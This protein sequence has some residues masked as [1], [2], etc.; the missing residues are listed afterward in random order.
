MYLSLPDPDPEKSIVDRDRA[1]VT[2][3]EIP[4]QQTIDR[5]WE[6]AADDPQHNQRPAWRSHAFFWAFSGRVGSA[7][8][9]A[10]RST[11]LRY[12]SC[13]AR[14]FMFAA[15]SPRTYRFAIP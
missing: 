15:L 11:F 6:F 13:S 7:Y 12:P 4:I 3:N 1:V 9:W 14:E 5:R 8:T 2:V 10:R